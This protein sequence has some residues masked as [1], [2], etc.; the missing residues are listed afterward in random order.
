MASMWSRPDTISAAVAA[1]ALSSSAGGGA[2]L[3]SSAP[4]TEAQFVE[5]T[6]ALASGLHQFG[7]VLGTQAGTSISLLME[8]AFVAQGSEDGASVE[9]P[10][11]VGLWV[12]GVN[13]EA[14]PPMRS[15]EPGPTDSSRGPL[16]SVHAPTRPPTPLRGADAPVKPSLYFSMGNC[17]SLSAADQ[18]ALAGIGESITNMTG[19]PVACA[20]L[21]GTW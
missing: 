7:L 19:F 14:V 5:A 4:T 11:P 15:P 3:P 6:A 10:A 2:S 8:P 16:P 18:A 1:A 9:G 12:V 20:S 21:P 17:S 13:R